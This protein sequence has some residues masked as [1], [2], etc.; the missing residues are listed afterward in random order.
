[1]VFHV[2]TGFRF[3]P[4]GVCWDRPCDVT[5]GSRLRYKDTRK[6]KATKHAKWQ[7]SLVVRYQCAQRSD[8][9][10]SGPYSISRGSLLNITTTT[11]R[12]L[13]KDKEKKSSSSRSMTSTGKEKDKEKEKSSTAMTRYPC[14]GY[15]TIKFISGKP[16]AQITI[17][18]RPCQQD[19]NGF[20]CHHPQYIGV[21]ISL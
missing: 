19:A 21:S 6:S 3:R 7:W 1:M 17:S 10:V 13:Q 9:Y 2:S 4:F 11:A 20:S 8:L 15:L 14:H 16:I 18:H 12:L 5:D